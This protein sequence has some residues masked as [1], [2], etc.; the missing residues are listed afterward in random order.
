MTQQELVEHL[1]VGEQDVGGVVAD[2]DAVGDEAVLADNGVGC[3]LLAGVDGGGDL[4]QARIGGDAVGETLSLVVGQ[5]VHGVE[6]EP[7]NAG[8]S[9]AA[10][11]DDVVKD[12]QQ[13]GL[14]LARPGAS[15][16]EGGLWAS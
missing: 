15:G 6:D 13:E 7:L 12:R 9:V 10:G 3:Y 16:D 2:D 8:D 1:V 14:C 4:G 5:S 11:S